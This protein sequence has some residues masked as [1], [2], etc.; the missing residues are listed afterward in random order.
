[1]HFNQRD[2]KANTYKVIHSVL[3]CT[4]LINQKTL[5]LKGKIFEKW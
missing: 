4:A 5:S 1:M 2:D 3:L